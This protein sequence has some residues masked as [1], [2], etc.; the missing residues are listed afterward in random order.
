MVKN[1]IHIEI[2]KKRSK[3]INTYNFD[4]WLVNVV[5]T[6]PGPVSQVN[7]NWASLG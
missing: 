3:N 7:G 6:I 4:A 2:H 1:T 5:N